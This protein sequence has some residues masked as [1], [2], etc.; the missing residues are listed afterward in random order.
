MKSGAGERGGAGDR[1]NR[2]QHGEPRGVLPLESHEPRCRDGHPRAARA[3]NQGQRLGQPDRGRRRPGHVLHAPR[4][5]RRPVGD[6]EQDAEPQGRPGD[7]RGLAQGV[8]AGLVE[9]EA[10]RAH[11]DG[12]QRQHA[13]Q[14]PAVGGAAPGESGENARDVAP[15]I[16]RDRE[17]RAGMDG[18]IDLEAL[19]GP[20]QD[21]RREHQVARRADRQEFGDALHERQDC[22]L[23]RGQGSQPLVRDAAKP[24]PPRPAMETAYRVSNADRLS[25]LPSGSQGRRLAWRVR[26]DPTKSATLTQMPHFARMPGRDG[27]GSA[28][29]QP[30]EPVQATPVSVNLL[31]FV[32]VP[33]RR[34]RKRAA[35]S[36]RNDFREIFDEFRPERAAE[37]A[38]RCSQCGIPFCQVHCPLHN[39]IPDWLSLTAENRLREA[40]ELAAATNTFPEICG[41][42]CPQDRLCEGNCV[43]EQGSRSRSP[44]A[45]SSATSP[46]PPSPTAGSRGPLRRSSARSLWRI[47]GA[48]PRPAL[49]AA[50]SLRRRGYRVEIYDR[51]DRAGGLLVY[52]IPNFKLEKSVV[53]RRV[54]LLEEAGVVFRLNSDVG[55]DVAFADL[56]AAHDAVLI[57][58][59]VYKRPRD[60]PAR[61]RSGQRRAGSRLPDRRQPARHGRRQVA[62]T[63][64]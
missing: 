13:R 15:E 38:A 47:V 31:A 45:R 42:I 49:A 60:R 4:G 54:A 59:G 25:R 18:N 52:G 41:R 2:K 64:G 29:S 19:V 39:N 34:P 55:R 26:F 10:D 58:N 51:H 61:R 43:I 9:R 32:D 53:A 24:I 35:H 3:G 12:S 46:K 23:K 11:R 50:D 62:G 1:G 36:R 8:D 27:L 5:R 44:S 21:L 48:G 63:D 14:R 37:Q 30:S 57:A 40:Y 16:H 17:Q 33:Q 56:R 28:S 6:E 7:D 20:A 22:K